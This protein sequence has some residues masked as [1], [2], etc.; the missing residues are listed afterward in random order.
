MDAGKAE[1]EPRTPTGCDP[2]LYEDLTGFISP[3]AHTR[4][5]RQRWYTR[6]DLVESQKAT[7]VLFLWVE[8]QRPS[9]QSVA[10]SGQWI[11]F[12]RADVGQG[13]VWHQVQHTVMSD[14]PKL[15]E[16]LDGVRGVSRDSNENPDWLRN[17][18]R[19]LL[20]ELLG[21]VAGVGVERVDIP[22]AV[23]KAEGYVAHHVTWCGVHSSESNVG[24]AEDPV[25]QVL[26]AVHALYGRVVLVQPAELHVLGF[27]DVDLPA[28]RKTSKVFG[29]QAEIPDQGAETAGVEVARL[30]EGHGVFHGVEGHGAVSEGQLGHIHEARAQSLLLVLAADQHIR[31]HAHRGVQAEGAAVTCAQTSKVNREEILLPRNIL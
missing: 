27:E 21:N 8:V 12:V 10:D 15:T 2:V 16:Q 18:P 23:E 30:V 3:C 24:A 14:V 4:T 11:D 19:S 17:L 6:L 9:F 13:L 28:V 26:G 25:A 22:T 31:Q 1:T 7:A 29:V 5:R 20:Q